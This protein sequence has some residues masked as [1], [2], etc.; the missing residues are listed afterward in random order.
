V[1]AAKL[2]DSAVVP[3]QPKLPVY[4]ASGKVAWFAPFKLFFLGVP[5][6]ALL[7]WLYALW[8]NHSPVWLISLFGLMLFSVFFGAYAWFVLK[9][10]HSRSHRFNTWGG[11]VLGFVGLW[12]HWALWIRMGFDQG[13]TLA[14][15]FIRSDP[16]GWANMLG[17]LAERLTQLEPT[18]FLVHW[19]PLLWL[20]EA[21]I[22]IWLPVVIARTLTSEPYSEA[23]GAWA[24]VDATGELWWEGGLSSELHSRLE[25]EG[26]A[27]LL[28]M[29][30]AVEVGLSQETRWWTASVIGQ[31]VAADPAARWL[32]V[33]IAEY[34]RAANGKIKTERFP[35]VAEWLVD[36]ADY[37]RLVS[38][39]RTAPLATAVAS[40]GTPAELLPAVAAMESDDFGR[41]IELAEDLRNHSDAALR[42]DALRLCALCLARLEKWNRA[43]DDYHALFACEPSV[44]NALQLAST[45]VM[46]DELARGQAWFEKASQLNAEKLT[47]PWPEL[48]TNFLSALENKGE[49]AAGL[50]QVEWLRDMF[51]D[52]TSSDD[53]FVHMHDMPFLSVFF[54]KS[55][56][57]LRA[58]MTEAEVLAWYG[59]MHGHLDA[60]GQEKLAAWLETLRAA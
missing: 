26:V 60:G 31:K 34:H 6:M 14:S 12:V 44:M 15:Y 1:K 55:L 50:P 10:A 17:L 48:Q 25:E 7:A 29:A 58:Q 33:S 4:L 35:V 24:S 38:H 49:W 36:A 53:H 41:A 32:T 30:R 20:A 9:Q 51:Q 3:A 45:S 18:R 2:N 5:G 40:G 47:M 37:D 52:M 21:A 46:A 59:A 8:L 56:P 11:A 42:A 22:L 28:T 57:F 27:F 19:L 43:F 54:E 23:L 39:L 13:P 16:V